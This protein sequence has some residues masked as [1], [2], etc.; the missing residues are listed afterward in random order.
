MDRAGHAFGPVDDRRWAAWSAAPWRS[1]LYCLVKRQWVKLAARDFG[2]SRVVVAA[3][4]RV[5]VRRAALR[6]AASRRARL[7]RHDG[8]AS[9]RSPRSSPSI[10]MLGVWP[11]PRQL[12]G[13]LG[14]LAC[15]GLIVWDGTHR[16]MAP[17]LLG[18][19]RQHA[20]QLR[21]RQHLSS[22]GS[23][24]TCRRRRSPTLFLAIG[25][26]G[27]RAARALARRCSSRLHLAVPPSPH[28]WPLAIAVARHA[29][30][31][32]H[33]HLHP[34][35]RPPHQN[36]R[37]AVRR[38]GHLRDPG[39]SRWSGASSTA[40]GSP[41]AQLAAIAGV[42]A[43]VALVQWNATPRKPRRRSSRPANRRRDEFRPA[44]NWQ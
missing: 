2:I 15:M 22:S 28:D 13:V 32:R 12:V 19:R 42:L 20:D 7:L 17:G 6:H 39:R 9:C 29:G 33:R 36:A 4:Q 38:H 1:P 11:T 40:S 10:P 16:G 21:P 18:A 14:G 34:G 30:R 31:R 44:S 35:L 25:A 43:M 24:T 23:S 41:A 8:H 5:A 37:P 26:A 27:A 3:G